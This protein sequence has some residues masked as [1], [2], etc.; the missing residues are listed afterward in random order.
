MIYRIY[1][2]FKAFLGIEEFA[3]FWIED[4]KVIFFINGEYVETEYIKDTSG[5]ERVIY[6]YKNKRFGGIIHKKGKE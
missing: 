3:A 5:Y 4:G 1:R 6:C 2:W